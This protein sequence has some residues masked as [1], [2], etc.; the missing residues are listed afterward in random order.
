MP[1]RAVLFDLWETLIN[2]TPERAMPRRVWRS[3]L[4]S[5]VLTRFDCSVSIED[6][7]EALDASSR[8]MA[9][10]HDTGRDVDS[11]GRAHLFIEE[12]E[13]IAGKHAPDGAVAE[14]EAAI[15]SMPLDIAPVAAP[16]AR[17]TVA[18]VKAMGLATALVCNAGFTTTPHLIPMLEHYGLAPHLDVQVFSDQLQIAK[19]D[20]RI[21]AAALDGL[22]LNA[23]D[24]VFI[25]DNPHT[26][27]DGAQR[28][29]LFAVQ[30][31][32]KARDGVTPDAR[33]ES[34]DQLIG[35]LQRLMAGGHG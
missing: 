6:V 27:I 17:E 15:T 10:L 33:I 12:L 24:C 14:L 8:R 22:G 21:F 23:A 4:V 11:A 3:G 2:D 32:T 34:L 18:A 1:L 26:D 31:G 16:F 19:P 30:I 35:V 13:T 28:A 9:A 29:G 25:G 5:E 7:G 20:P